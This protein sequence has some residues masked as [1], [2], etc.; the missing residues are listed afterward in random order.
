LNAGLFGGGDCADER[1]PFD[2]TTFED[3]VSLTG[4]AHGLQSDHLQS[5]GD[6]P[7]YREELGLKQGPASSPFQGIRR[8]STPWGLW[9]S[10]RSA[11]PTTGRS[12]KLSQLAESQLGTVCSGNQPATAAANV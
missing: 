7:C 10:T 12:E 4:Q 3:G 2:P 1:N 8:R 11:T 6:G 9:C 5:C